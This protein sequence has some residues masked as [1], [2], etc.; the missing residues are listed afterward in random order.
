[1]TPLRPLLVPP[2]PSPSRRPVATVNV[3][4]SPSARAALG[5]AKVNS[6]ARERSGQ[7]TAPRAVEP[8]GAVYER[9]AELMAAARARGLR[10]ARFLE[11][12][13]TRVALAAAAAALDA[14]GPSLG[15]LETLTR[16]AL[17]ASA[18]GV[19]GVA[20]ELAGGA[21]GGGDRT[22]DGAA[23]ARVLSTLLDGKRALAA[24]VQHA[25]QSDDV[26]RRV[27]GALLRALSSL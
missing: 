11:R 24:L 7:P 25:P 13:A 1:M 8:P 4:S 26:T 2:L 22:R 21:L 23:Y 14:R 27:G 12:P 19:D 16:D 20:G 9:A 6:D 15:R 18:A 10:S 3:G 5:L 17:R